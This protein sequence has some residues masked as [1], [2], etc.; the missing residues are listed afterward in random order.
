VSLGSVL[1]AA[2][3]PLGALLLGYPTS[4]VLAAVAV[5]V[6][7][8]VRHRENIARL[9]AGTERSVSVRRPA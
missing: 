9:L 7:V 4:A 2:C 8:V 3:V 1:A 6:I 5:A